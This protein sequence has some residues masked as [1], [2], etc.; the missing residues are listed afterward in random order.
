MLPKNDTC[1]KVKRDGED[2]CNIL[3]FRLYEIR[4]Y[5][6]DNLLKKSAVSFKKSGAHDN[7]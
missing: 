5:N 2:M 3:E 1:K 7:K 6:I 4:I